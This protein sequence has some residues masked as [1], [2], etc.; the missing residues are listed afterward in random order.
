MNH[1]EPAY[2]VDELHNS[3]GG[4]YAQHFGMPIRMHIAIAA[5]QGMLANNNF[6]YPP[7]IDANRTAL[8]KEAWRLADD[9]IEY[10][11]KSRT[12]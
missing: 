9:M 4:V 12:S 1:N 5:M 11:N 8:V 10:G 7:L 3:H 2:P 6:D